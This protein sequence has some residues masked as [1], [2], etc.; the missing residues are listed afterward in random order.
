MAMTIMLPIGRTKYSRTVAPHLRSFLTLKQLFTKKELSW[1]KARTPNLLYAMQQLN[2]FHALF[3]FSLE[4]T[5][6]KKNTIEGIQIIHR[7][8][9][10]ATAKTVHASGID[11]QF[12]RIRTKCS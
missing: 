10:L 12:F 5:S 7:S 3:C 8:Q 4:H 2:P 9:T 6:R 11:H 1:R